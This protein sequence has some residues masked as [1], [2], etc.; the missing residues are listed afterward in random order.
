MIILID[1]WSE[2]IFS[3]I[4]QP[5]SHR[6]DRSESGTSS[7]IS[8]EEEDD[9]FADEHDVIIGN[10]SFNLSEELHLPSF[11]IRIH[12]LSPLTSFRFNE[13]RLVARDPVTI[14]QLWKKMPRFH[15][16]KF[17]HLAP[18]ITWLPK[19]NW[20]KDAFVPTLPSIDQIN[21]LSVCRISF[22]G[23]LSE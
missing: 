11:G 14:K 15:V 23:S 6:H 17:R 7:L 1:F 8:V 18:I 22:A 13:D 10:P 20:R 4:F 5:M 19:Y 12:L 9:L 21:A 16:R 2:I 3:I